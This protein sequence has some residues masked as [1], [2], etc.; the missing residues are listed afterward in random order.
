M[1]GLTGESMAQK[2]SSPPTL[3]AEIL[4]EH[5]PEGV[6]CIHGVTFDGTLVWFVDGSRNRLV[7]FDPAT[8]KVVREIPGVPA[9]AGLA[10]D[11]QH[12][13]AVVGRAIWKLNIA[14][15]AKLKEIP[16]PDPE[17][18][19]GLAWADGALYAGSYRAGKLFKLDP[20]TGRV[21]KTIPS[22]RFVTG[23][24]F[25]DGELWHG[26]DAAEADGHVDNEVRRIDAD[27]GAVL[28]RLRMPKGTH[29]SGLEADRSGR[30]W[31]GDFRTGKLRSVRRA[32][33]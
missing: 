9:D 30:F 20:E 28:T 23:I 3:D 19:T 31:L 5:A 10:Y 33:K 24:S 6:D 8:G 29:V 26:A 32:S 27:T 25:I 14:S 21:L 2:L 16:T 4:S 22:D 15:G 17:Q 12:L 1:Q 7:A 13:W 11:G 18:T